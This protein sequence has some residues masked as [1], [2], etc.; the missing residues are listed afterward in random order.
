[1]EIPL[2]NRKGEVVANAIVSEEDYE[3]LIQFKWCKNDQDYVFS[4][5]NRKS[6]KLHRYIVIIL[7][8]NNITS[9]QPIDHINNN[10]LDNTRENL[11]I[12]TISE[13]ARNKEKILRENTTSKYIGVSKNNNTWAAEIRL[14]DDRLYASYVDEIHAAHQYNLWVK[15]YNLKTAKIN[16]IDIPDDFIEYI[17]KSKELPKGIHLNKKNKYIVKQTINSIR[18]HIGA[19]SN[20]NDAIIAL[21]KV[22]LQKQE[23]IKE[24]LYNTPILYNQNGDCIFK[25]NEFD[26]L[27]DEELYYDIIQYKWHVNIHGYIIAN[28]NKKDIRLHRYIMNYSGDDFIDHINGNRLDNRKSNLRIATPQQNS[29]NTSSRKNSTSQYIGVNFDKSRNKFLA[30]INIDNTSINLGRFDNEIDAAKSR[31]IA[32]KEH[33]GEF[34]RLNFPDEI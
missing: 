13:N 27:I 26:I 15:A 20:L 8:G 1:M 2:K 9:K 22:K 3:Y 17:P 12:V 30:R 6:W 14:N 29:R 5:I 24:K 32:S 21:E 31:D 34:A 28:I 23:N 7:L 11:R 18:K 25:I 10:P 19:Y 16:E 4:K 33:F